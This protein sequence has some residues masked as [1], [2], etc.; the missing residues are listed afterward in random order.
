MPPMAFRVCYT[1]IQV[2]AILLTI[3]RLGYRART[4]MF[5]VEDM[6][7]AAALVCGVA[8]LIAGWTYD[9]TAG[10]WSIISFWVY[11]FAFPSAI[12]AVRQSIL[13]SVARIFW[14][15]RLLR[16]TAIIIS[17]VFLVLYGALVTQK[18]WQ[19]GHDLNWYHHPDKHGKVHAYLSHPMVIFELMTDFVSDA[20]LVLLSLHLLWGVKL[21]AKERRMILATFSASIIVT[22][23]SVFRSICQIMQLRSILRIATDSELAVS[24]IICNLLV[25]TTYIY[26]IIARRSRSVSESESKSESEIELSEVAAPALQSPV[27]LDGTGLLTTIDLTNYSWDSQPVTEAE[28]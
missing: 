25:A 24:L 2:S 23:V 15:M 5:W 28:A 19:Y 3:L 12:W 6:W 1:V 13:F 4:Q 11:S 27:T 20:I 21:L 26:R 8:S 22:I 17:V 7:A 18:A 16:L 9:Y 10:Q 14:S